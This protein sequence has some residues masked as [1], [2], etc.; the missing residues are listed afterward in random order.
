VPLDAAL[1]DPMRDFVGI[2]NRPRVAREAVPV[3]RDLAEVVKPGAAVV[4][5][6]RSKQPVLES[7]FAADLRR[8]F[9][10][11]GELVAAAAQANGGLL[12]EASRR[13]RA[14][15][16]LIAAASKL[17]VWTRRRLLPLFK[18]HYKR[19]FDATDALL[20]T[21]DITPTNR[22]L[23]EKAVLEAGGKHMGLMDITRDV[24]E[25]LFKVIDLGRE[26]GLNPRD[27]GRLIR[28]YVPRGRFIHAG[29][30]YRSQMIARTEVL[31]G[32]RF[33]SLSIYESS[34]V[35][36]GAVAFDGDHD[37]ECAAR[38]GQVF[39]FEEAFTIIDATHPQCV[40]AFGPAT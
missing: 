9:L 27:T 34:P 28:E 16:A 4:A 35:V 37:D 1:Q 5:D 39:S 26:R 36:K 18:Y 3:L 40:L 31:H 12:I 7:L 11:L 13:E 6:L 29:S 15:V 25:S 2:L 8:E 32:Q 22:D 19:I 21:H 20:K 24:K 33:A 38:N 23:I 14:R 17:D 30:G 10:L